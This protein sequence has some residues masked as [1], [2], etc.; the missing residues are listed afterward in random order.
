MLQSSTPLE[1]AKSL[2]RLLLKNN[3]FPYLLTNFFKIELYI[4]VF[5]QD[6]TGVLVVLLDHNVL[7]AHTCV[8]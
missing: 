5:R 1:S 2:L 7:I 8:F 6:I 4:N 3:I